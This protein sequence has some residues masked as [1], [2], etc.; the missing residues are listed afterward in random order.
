LADR[1]AKSADQTSGYAIRP[2]ATAGGI[3][4]AERVE[5]VAIRRPAGAR[6]S[7]TRSP[8][9]AAVAVATPMLK[10]FVDVPFTSR[11]QYLQI[12]ERRLPN[13]G[14]FPGGVFVIF[15]SWENL[16]ALVDQP[17]YIRDE[18]A[19]SQSVAPHDSARLTASALSSTK[20]A[21]TNKSAGVQSLP[22]LRKALAQHAAL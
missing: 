14:V 10:V 4:P 19:P 17:I 16:D 6:A 18:R 15:D 1:Q 3:I 5:V 22:T 12:G 7:S 11:Q 9:D 13:Y 20:G 8:K 2:A 21:L